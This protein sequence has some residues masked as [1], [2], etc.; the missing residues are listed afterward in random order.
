MN[1][2]EFLQGYIRMAE[3]G[4]KKG[5]H[6][7]NGGN[8][9]YRMKAQDV[10][11]MKAEFHFDEAWRPIGASVP[12]LAGEYFLVTGSG[13]YL[14]NVPLAPEENI[15]IA[16]I[17]ESGR[18]IRWYGDLPRADSRRANFLPI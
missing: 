15:A 13:K 6:E 12:N 14:A 7:R 10:A 4:A 16:R 17:D 2:P 18:T 5:W 3:N 9:S 8:L 1:R 11:D